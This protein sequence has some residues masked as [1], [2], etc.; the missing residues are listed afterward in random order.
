MI[1]AQSKRPFRSAIELRGE[2]SFGARLFL[3]E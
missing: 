2:D 1:A 3:V